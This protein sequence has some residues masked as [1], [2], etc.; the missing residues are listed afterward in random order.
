MI[1]NRLNFECLSSSTCSPRFN[2]IAANSDPKLNV[3]VN[4]SGSNFMALSHS[5]DDEFNDRN[6]N[7]QLDD[8]DNSPTVGHSYPSSGSAGHLYAGHHST[9]GMHCFIPPYKCVQKCMY[10]FN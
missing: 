1:L 4:M 9:A 10:M 2:P 5:D 6:H 8:E 3:R 7:F